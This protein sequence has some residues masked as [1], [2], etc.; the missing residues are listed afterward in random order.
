MFVDPE[1]AKGGWNKP[2]SPLDLII[3]PKTDWVSQNDGYLLLGGSQNL[4]NRILGRCW[5][6]LI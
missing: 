4:E 1:P 5:G 3:H 6:P 2:L